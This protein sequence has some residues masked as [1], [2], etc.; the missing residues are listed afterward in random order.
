MANLLAP[1][2]LR[3]GLEI[4]ALISF[5]V[6]VAILFYGNNLARFVEA[7]LTLRLHWVLIGV[8]VASLDWIVGGL[9]L[10]VLL[11]HVYPAQSLKG[12]VISAGINAF[13]MMITPSQ[14]GGGPFGIAALKRYGTPVPEAMVATLM[15]FVATILFFIVAGPLVVFLGAGDS[16]AER[17]I[18]GVASLNDLFRVSLGGFVTVGVVILSLILF[19]G[20]ARRLA[21]RVVGF[22]ERR[23]NPK[24]ASR[25]AEL[26]DGI[27]RAH[28]AMVAYFSTV[29]GW[30][31]LLASIPLTGGALANKLLAGYIVLRALGLEA[32]FIDV[33]MLQTL[34][35]FLLYFAP[36]PGGSGL[37]EVLSGAVMSIYVPRELTPSYVLLWRIFYAYLTVAAGSFVFWRWLKDWEESS[38]APPQVDN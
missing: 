13:G 6:F 35:M 20:V 12:S 27:D 10:Y 25:V 8:G 9:R 29:R 36:T 3:R 28:Q 34:V 21:R 5:V 32:P 37:A 14:A 18:L 4:F 22:F 2:I 31:A 1:Q 24:I 15:S 38:V 11:K 16:L 33:I 7:M 30:L 26:N 19:P 17:G 23:G